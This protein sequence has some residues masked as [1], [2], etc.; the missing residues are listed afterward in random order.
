L[1][2]PPPS[3]SKRFTER[4]TVNACGHEAN[5]VR[6]HADSRPLMWPSG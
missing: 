6:F 2:L 4:P 5:D 1:V 3:R